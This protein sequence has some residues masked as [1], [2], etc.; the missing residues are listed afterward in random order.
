MT[1]CFGLVVALLLGCGPSVSEPPPA[2]EPDTTGSS[3]SATDGETGL[4]DCAEPKVVCDNQCV[5]LE[6]DNDHCGTCGHAC[7]PTQSF[8]QCWLAECTPRTHCVFPDEPYRTCSEVCRRDGTECAG[9]RPDNRKWVNGWH[10]LYYDD[11]GARKCDTL[12]TPD[13][14]VDAACDDPIDWT[15]LGGWFDRPP[16]AAS[17]FCVQP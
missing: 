3:S 4:V 1:R 9:P 8:G 16:V 17:C 12:S 13:K 2:S 10:G 7:A 5:D 6:Y 15:V 14:G 11:S